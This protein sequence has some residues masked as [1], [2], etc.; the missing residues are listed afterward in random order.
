M[1][2]LERHGI[3][4]VIL[5]VLLIA[6]GGGVFLYKRA[7]IESKPLEI[8]L[9]TPTSSQEIVVHITGEVV[10]PGVYS[11]E[12]GDRIADA[13]EAAG[14]LTPDADSDAIN[15]ALEV[16]Y[17]DYIHI[18]RIGETPQR[19]NIN[20]A[21]AWLLQALPG[22]GESRAQAIIDYRAENGPFRSIDELKEVPGIGSS[23][24]EEIEDLITVD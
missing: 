8:V 15:L 5:L 16:E 14:G 20:T 12:E 1:S 18:P 22:I 10:N 21:E 6:A 17:E 13:V 23:T 9:S 3:P 11:L 19:V 2:W 4:I 7:N 24:F